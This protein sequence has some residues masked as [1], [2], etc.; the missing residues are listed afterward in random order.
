MG[1]GERDDVLGVGGGLESGDGAVLVAAPGDDGDGG[2]VGAAGGGAEGDH[3]GGGA[4]AAFGAER[5]GAAGVGEAQPA[6]RHRVG[7]EDGVAG[8]ADQVVVGVGQSEAAGGAGEPVEVAGDR[9]G[10]AVDGLHGLEH[11]VAGGESVVEDGQGR[12]R[13]VD[14]GAVDPAG[15]RV[16][17]RGGLL[18]GRARAGRVRVAAGAVRVG[19]S[20]C[21][22]T[23]RHPTLSRPGG[24]PSVRFPPI[25]V[26]GRSP[27]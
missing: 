26:R 21:R 24:P 23:S 3:Q 18:A 19:F 27:R 15:G 7:G 17:H 12:V 5:R 10:P 20:R 8:L 22:G 1:G 9:E 4:V 13:G 2:G 11:A 25:L 16:L 6:E 14:E